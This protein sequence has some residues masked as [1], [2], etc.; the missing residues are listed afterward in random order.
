MSKTYKT[1][2]PSRPARPNLIFVAIC[3]VQKIVSGKIVKTRSVAELNTG[4]LS[5]LNSTKKSLHLTS[6]NISSISLNIWAP[7]FAW[8]S[9]RIPE[10][11]DIAT[12]GKDGDAGEEIYN[13]L[14]SDE[15]I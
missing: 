5:A 15:E 4:E 3:K 1:L 6:L 12:L 9:H 2:S 8:F 11:V 7:T 13:E 14:F 10:T